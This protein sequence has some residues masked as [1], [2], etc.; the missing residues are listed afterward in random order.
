MSK[1]QSDTVDRNIR[2]V[3]KK[4]KAN[5]TINGKQKYVGTY[6]TLKEAQDARDKAEAEIVRKPNNKVVASEKK[7]KEYKKEL[8]GKKYGKL[9]IKDVYRERRNG[10]AHYRLICKC[11]CGNETRPYLSSVVGSNAET[12]S[13]G[14]YQGE[15][16]TKVLDSYLYDGTRVTN[17]KAK[18]R[19]KLG[20]KGVRLTKSGT[21]EAAISFKGE[22]R[23][24]GTYKTLEEAASARKEAE[25]ELF[26]PVINDFN[27][28]AKYKVK[29]E[30][31][32]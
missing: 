28:T 11:D 31:K 32:K 4:Y 15:S 19:N 21:Y 20:V 1:T 12:V 7:F 22:R 14:C 26:D 16:G 9:T 17:L 23:Y 2:K 24:L 18:A 6:P 25:K 13:C 29:K 5:V 3:G 30:E 8:I 27:K 10:K